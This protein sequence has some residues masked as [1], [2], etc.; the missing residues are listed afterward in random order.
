MAPYHVRILDKAAR[1]LSRLDKPTKQRV[2]ERIGWLANNVE[3]VKHEILTADLSGLYKL[4]VGEYRV[5]YE[6]LPRE[7]TVIIHLV[8]HRREI[9]KKR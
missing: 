7:E 3:D 4:R 9:Y 8:G 1:D 6:M 5:I 2:I